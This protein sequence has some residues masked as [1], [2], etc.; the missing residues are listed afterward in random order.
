MQRLKLPVALVVGLTALALIGLLGTQPTARSQAVAPPAP[1]KPSQPNYCENYQLTVSSGTQ[2][3]SGTVDL[4]NNC[5]DC[6]T[7]LALPFAYQVYSQTY[8]T[9][10]VSS[11]GRLDFRTAHD[12]GAPGYTNTCLPASPDTYGPFDYTIFPHWDDLTTIGGLAGC[13][14]YATGCGV[15]TSVSGSAP[16]RVFN[17]E[18]RAVYYND[19]TLPAN[20]EVRLYEG[21][22]VFHIIYGT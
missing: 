18:W 3:V 6:G 14:G 22:P 7:Q 21:Q 20:F 1:G 19:N 4:G 5:D 16:N 10:L 13:A 17:I 9:V 8:S 2:I 15:F 12:P 11:N